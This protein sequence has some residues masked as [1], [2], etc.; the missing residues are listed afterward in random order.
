MD[1]WVDAEFRSELAAVFRED[2]EALEQMLDRDL[3]HWV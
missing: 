2:R 1:D 3:S